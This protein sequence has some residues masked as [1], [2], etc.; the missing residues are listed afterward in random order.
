MSE[1]SY[2]DRRNTHSRKWD[3]CKERFGTDDL[4]PLWIADMDFAAPKCV[5]EAL[6]NY[7]DFGVFGYYT[8]SQEYYDAFINW[9]KFYHDYQVEQEW[10]RFAPGVVPAFNWFLHILTK[11]D[12][13]VIILTPVYYPFQD[14][15]VNNGRQLVDCPLIRTENTYEIDYTDFENKIIAHNV[16]ACIF[17]SPHNPV[18]RVWKDWELIKVLDICKKHGVYL[19]SDEIHQDIIMDGY[20]QIPAATLGDYDDILMTLTAATKTF[21][22]AAC[23][24]AILVIPNE[25]LRKRYDEYLTRLRITGGNPFG[26]IAV[27]SAYESGREWLEEVLGIIEANYRYMKSRME[28]A[29]PEVWIPELQGTYLMWIDLKKY[30]G[31]HNIESVIQGQCG[32]AVDYG[33]WF[34]GDR[35]EGCF[36]INLATKPDNIKLAA[37]RIIQALKR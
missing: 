17:C 5:R 4:L 29:L 7:V 23:Q 32:L 10:I 1:V 14:A 3:G 30:V 37:D 25:D 12:D 19:L 16:K 36:R 35:Y 28:E 18:G 26:Y 6:R 13:G 24:N 2:Q 9:E 11:K 34:G 33:T 15:I 21:N 27:Q 22:L 8:P 20:T 31:V